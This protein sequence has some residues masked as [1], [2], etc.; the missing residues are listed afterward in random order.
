MQGTLR[1]FRVAEILQL[2]AVQ[3]KTGLLRVQGT[4]TT[5][6]FYFERGVLVSCRD[7]RR[8]VADPLL[9]YVRRTGWVESQTARQLET[10]TQ[11]TRDD[12]ADLL[13]ERQIITADELDRI[14]EDLAQ[15]L[16]T[17][18]YSWNDGSYLFITG[19]EALL[20]LKH[21]MSRNVEGLLMEAARRADEWPRLLEKIPG[22][23][24]VVGDLQQV[25]SGLDETTR[26]IL[27]RLQQ[28][29]TM[30]ELASHA[31]VPEF[32]VY[33]TVAQAIENRMARV[34]EKPRRKSAPAA[35]SLATEPPAP[36]PPPPGMPERRRAFPGSSLGARARRV[37]QWGV[38]LV[39]TA[40][41]LLGSA[42][43]FRDLR[44]PTTP[45]LQQVEAARARIERDLEVHRAVF[46]MYPE[47][48]DAL[49]ESDLTPQSTL[50]D[51]AV[52][53]FRPLQ[54][55]ARYRIAYQEDDPS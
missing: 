55:G 40:A 35:F 53:S 43:A 37:L 18:S 46:G 47:T 11:S 54:R 5:L 30:H 27:D 34:L 19:E 23:E 33:E 4:Q 17:S 13:L 15:D 1:D 36:S 12:L 42:D 38:A 39:V 2:V 6:T 49:V 14:L 8:A 7:R 45:T 50:R 16:I 9:D 25:P 51:A 32:E 20:G 29:I 24:T 31:R 48:L 3:Q 21:R 22:P 41:A 26:A 44:R 10:E 28:P 52:R